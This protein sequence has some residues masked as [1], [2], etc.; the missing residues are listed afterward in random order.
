MRRFVLL[1]FIVACKKSAPPPT[2]NQ[3]VDHALALMGQGQ[4]QGPTKNH[5]EMD[6]SSKKP[7][8][9]L[10]T[11]R[12]L[13]ED[14]A[15]CMYEAPSLEVL[16]SCRPIPADASAKARLPNV[17]SGSGSGSAAKPAGSGSPP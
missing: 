1:L 6:L 17:G 12:H 13:T 14:Q 15:R 8:I 2:C 10:C 4:A 3:I 5:D 16:N 9:Q 7:M 11:Q